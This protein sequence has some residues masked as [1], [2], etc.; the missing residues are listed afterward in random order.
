MMVD[1]PPEESRVFREEA[2]K[3]NISLIYLLAPN[4]DQNRMEVVS[5]HSSSFI[6]YVSMTGVTGS[7]LVKS[8]GMEQQVTAIKEISKKPVCVGFGIETGQQAAEISAFADGV[9]VGSALVKLIEQHG[10]DR[11]AIIKKV[12][13]KTRELR[14]AIR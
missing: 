11:K 3:K 1:F 10:D 13:A 4:S 9:I 7:S 14:S 5:S 2:A 6:Y 12:A 8:K